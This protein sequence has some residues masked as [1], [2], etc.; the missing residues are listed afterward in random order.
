MNLGV[1]ALAIVMLDALW[2]LTGGSPLETQL[3]RLETKLADLSKSVVLVE[4]ARTV[5]L[6]NVFERQGDFGTE[7]TWENMLR[8]A[9][10]NVDLMARTGFGWTRSRE[11]P[12]IIR[13][14]VAHDVQ[15]R[16]LIMSRTNPHLSLLVEE[17]INIGS[18][19]QQKL[20]QVE[21]FARA[22]RDQLPADQKHSFQV[23]VFTGTAGYCSI[24]RLDDRWYITHYLS[25]RSSDDSPL[26]CASGSDTSWPTAY[27][28]EFEAVWRD[29]KDLFA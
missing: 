12:D 20:E 8:G 28:G 4:G 29:A 23:R 3:Q 17:D 27:R 18:M 24:L 13:D 9:R 1:A 7:T 2:R 11:I 25:S 15:F 6:D 10:R 22:I 19:L 21:K 16:W 26:S 14:R 5:G